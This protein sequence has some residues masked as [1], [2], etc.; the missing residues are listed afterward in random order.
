METALRRILEKRENSP[1]SGSTP[2]AAVALV[3][4]GQSDELL[5]IQR[6]EDPRDPWS[7][8]MAL[9]RG[10]RGPVDQG[11]LATAMRETWGEVGVR[12][13]QEHLLGELPPTRT[14]S[15]TND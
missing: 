7:G 2:Q 9:P 6:A 4:C 10:R 8:H 14:R 13:G 11:L 3:L 1:P 15:R 12:L 5:L